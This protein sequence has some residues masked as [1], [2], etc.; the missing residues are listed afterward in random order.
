MPEQTDGSGPAGETG[1]SSTDALSRLAAAAPDETWRCFVAVELP[2]AVQSHLSGLLERIPSRRRRF[3][4]PVSAGGIHVTLKFLGGMRPAQTVEAAR[5]LEDAAGE[6][7]PFELQ[8][9]QTGVFPTPRKPGVLWAG[10]NGETRRLL[11][12][13]AR[14]EGAVSALGIAPERRPYSPHATVARLRRDA[15][16]RTAVEIGKAWLDLSPQAISFTVERIAL[17]R[18]YLEP[19]GARYERLSTAPLS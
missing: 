12:L 1:L 16:G 17:F 14:V 7:A 19:T 10:F 2:D 3:V 15:R 5:L 6:S 4:Q 13:Q 18:S 11:R 8:L 9:A